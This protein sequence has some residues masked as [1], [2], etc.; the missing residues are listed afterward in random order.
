[1]A[2]Q[3]SGLDGKVALVTGA[4]RMRSIGREIA[5]ALARAG[6]DVLITG[7]G[8]APEQYPDEEKAA[9]WRD[10]DSVADEIRALGR[11]ALPVVCD[12]SSE[13]ACVALVERCVAELGR[14][15]ILVNN[16]SA[17]RGP[18]RRNV[19]DL[20]PAVWRHVI[21]VNL[22]GPFYLS[23][24]AARQMVAQGAGGSIVNISSIAG[25]LL[26]AQ[27]AAY[28]ASKAGLQALTAAMASELGRNGIRVNAICPGIIDTS[29]LD[30]IPRADGTWDRLLSQY[31]PLGRAGRPE[32]VAAL[33]A[34][35]CSEQGA[36]ISGQFY[37][38]DGGQ[39]PGR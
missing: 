35:L 27:H 20:E 8:R 19:V 37:S 22:H 17:S 14:V 13:E 15:D 5:L 7:S 1:M 3:P 32:E 24:G 30:D 23:Q 12:V 34:F 26:P 6:C 4:G 2:L 25:K 39:A 16:A 36:W 11:R 29:R 33:A 31:V 28:A 18:D 21:D 10:V 9:G 38:I